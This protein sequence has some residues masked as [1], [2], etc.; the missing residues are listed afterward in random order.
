MQMLI[1][2]L[3]SRYYERTGARGFKAVVVAEDVNSGDF[4]DFEFDAEAGEIH[5]VR[6][7]DQN[8]PDGVDPEYVMITKEI[9]LFGSNVESD[10]EVV[11]CGEYMIVTLKSG[12]ILL[13]MGDDRVVMPSRD[14]ELSSVPSPR[15]NLV[16]WI[17]ISNLMGSFVYWLGDA[18]DLRSDFVYNAI[19]K[20]TT[21]EA[22]YGEALHGMTIRKSSPETAVLDI[23]NGE[24]AKFYEQLELKKRREELAQMMYGVKKS[25]KSSASFDDEDDFQFDESQYEDGDDDFDD[26]DFSEDI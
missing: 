11:P 1:G 8:I 13:N 17:S 6:S 15:M 10:I 18:T 14:I 3:D 23:S 12:A 7:A 22:K 21:T 24:L 26:D 5:I 16:Y 2:N 25:V 9:G 4:I 20:N 19:V